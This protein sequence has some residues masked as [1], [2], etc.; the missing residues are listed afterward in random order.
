MPNPEEKGNEGYVNS[1]N[2]ALKTRGELRNGMVLIP[3]G[4]RLVY[5]YS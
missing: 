1:G 3:A 2:L 5:P 4:R